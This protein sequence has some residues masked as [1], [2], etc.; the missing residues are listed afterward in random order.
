MRSEEKGQTGI[1][2]I[3]II[4][5]ALTAVFMLTTT[6]VSAQQIDN[7]VAAIVGRTTP[8]KADT[9][10]V[11]ELKKTNELAS[12]INDAAKP[13]SPEL[14]DVDTAAK[15]INATVPQILSSAQSINATVKPIN[16]N[17]VTILGTAR[18]IAGG[19][20][21]LGGVRGINQ[22]LDIALVPVRAIKSDTASILSDT[23]AIKFDLCTLP[24]SRC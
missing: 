4:A 15:S 5:W 13:I 10:F 2:L 22:R 8:I 16:G 12:D 7:R 24:T 11:A 20:S 1:A 3:I 19:A 6:L 18:E 21:T 23:N 9:A 17:L 14:G